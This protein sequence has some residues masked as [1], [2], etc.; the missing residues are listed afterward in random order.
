M[1]E[2]SMRELNFSSIS[3][4][5]RK[6]S[7]LHMTAFALHL[8]WWSRLSSDLKPLSSTRKV[9]IYWVSVKMEIPLVSSKK[10]Q[11]PNRLRYL[12]PRFYIWISQRDWHL[13]SSYLAASF[14]RLNSITL[15]SLVGKPLLMGSKT[16]NISLLRMQT[17]SKGHFWHC[18][19]QQI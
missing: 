16:L 15:E 18:G 1:K 7:M 17:K 13:A 4:L 8:T 5:T 3:N 19:L 6:N 11:I 14:Q 10:H 2:L 12:P 9:S